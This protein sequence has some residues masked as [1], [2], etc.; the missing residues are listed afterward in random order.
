LPAPEPG[1]LRRRRRRPPVPG[2][3]GVLPLLTAPR[4]RVLGLLWLL[5][6][7]PRRLLG[8]R[9]LRLRPLRVLGE[10]R[11]RLFPL[12]RHLIR[13]GVPPRDHSEFS[14]MIR[15]AGELIDHESGPTRPFA[16]PSPQ[17][18]RDT[19]CAR[20]AATFK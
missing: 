7:S 8:L 15:A 12:R 1:L 11:R 20:Q 19:R 2:L 17:M 16:P 9:V 10:L 18:R 5:G 3:L 6:L 4:L 13:H 14:F